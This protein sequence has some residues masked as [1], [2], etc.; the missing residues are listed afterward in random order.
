MI[1]CMTGQDVEPRDLY[2]PEDLGRVIAELRRRRG[3]SQAELAQWLG[4][5][6][7]TVAKLESQGAATLPLALRALTLLGAVPT[8]HLKSTHLVEKPSD[9]GS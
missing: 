9:A 8:V 7:P 2:K 4:V 3:W 6:R 5:S 1:L